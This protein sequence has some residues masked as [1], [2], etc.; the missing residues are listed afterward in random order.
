MVF[1][2]ILYLT[3]EDK[4][5]LGEKVQIDSLYVDRF[6]IAVDHFVFYA[7]E[8]LQ[9]VS[10][11]SPGGQHFSQFY[12]NATIFVFVD[13]VTDD[14]FQIVQSAHLLLLSF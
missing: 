13:I 4:A 1:Q 11:D 5:D 9:P 2:Q 8:R 14:T 10:G 12:F 7:G 3:V 6:I